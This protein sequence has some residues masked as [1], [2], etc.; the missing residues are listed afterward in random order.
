MPE[1]SSNVMPSINGSKSCHKQTVSMLAGS[2][3]KMQVLCTSPK[4]WLGFTG[5]LNATYLLKHLVGKH[6]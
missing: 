6:Y 5:R 3:Q 2:M 4:L 1:I